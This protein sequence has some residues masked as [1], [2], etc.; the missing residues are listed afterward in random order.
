VTGKTHTICGVAAMGLIVLL[1]PQNLTLGGRELIPAA[2]LVT[3][4]L[5]SL[6]PDIDIPNSKIGSKVKWLSKHLKHRG[7]THTLLIPV[8]T[9]F[10]M[11]TLTVPVVPSLLFGLAVGWTAHIAADMFNSKGVPLLWPVVRGRLSIASFKTRSWHEAVFVILWFSAL[12]A[13]YMF[14]R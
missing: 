2:G 14:K 5:G 3:A 11:F 13:F 1:N 9:V 10:A 6:L 8:L 12:I 7:I 4:G